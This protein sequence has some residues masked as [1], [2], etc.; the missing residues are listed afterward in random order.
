[1]A[2]HESKT[3]VIAALT[4]NTLIAITKFIAAAMSG[5]S[6]MLSEAL[7]SCVD[8]CNQLLLLYGMQRA[9]RPADPSHPYGYGKELY[10]WTFVVAVLVFALG[11]GLSIYEGISHLEHAEPLSNLYINYAVLAAALVFEGISWWIAWREFHRRRRRETIFQ[12]VHR[13]K[14]PTLIA[15]LFEDSA[16]MLG[17]LVAFAGITASQVFHAPLFDALASITIGVIL[18]AVALWLAYESKGLLVG[19]SA[20]PGT[21]EDIRRITTE[22]DRVTR[23]VDALTMHLGPDDVLLTLDV[24]FADRLSTSEVEETVVDLEQRIQQHHPEIKRIFIE[25]RSWSRRKKA[26]EADGNRTVSQ[27]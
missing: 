20:D 18:G 13:T 2:R 3:A 25:A 12:A 26:G 21:L 1:M 16:A 4:G 6:A 8:C 19:E 11:A 5:S 15:V 27:A 24:D 10:F 14:D 9:A 22:D 7:H 23:L 17:L